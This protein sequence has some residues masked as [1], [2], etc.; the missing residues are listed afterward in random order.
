[1]CNAVAAV[2]GVSSILG[3]SSSKKA[4]KKAGEA[5][6]VSSQIAMEQLNFQRELW[7]YYK[8]QYQ[9]L[10]TQ[11][12]AEAG[13]SGEVLGERYASEAGADVAQAFD[14]SR[15]IFKRS[16]GGFGITPGPEFAG[17]EREA[18][19]ERAAA[20]AGARTRGR[21]LGEDVAF[22]RKLAATRIGRN[23]PG[24]AI[25]AGRNAANIQA[26][27]GD[28]YQNQADESARLV[29][30]LDYGAIS[31]LVQPSTQAPTTQNIAG[32]DPLQPQSGQ[33]RTDLTG[34]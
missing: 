16:M 32:Y 30:G 33:F 21:R 26:G 24:E 22:D 23:L 19:T 7:D 1:M 29:A 14:K 25:S 8:T 12:I 4:S 17:I 27:I 9:P 6:D 11:M 10:E 5:A 15:E 28:F 2:M 3:Y 13:V 18:L 31:R 20:E 34:R